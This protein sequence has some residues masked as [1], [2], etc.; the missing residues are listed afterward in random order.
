VDVGEKEQYSVYL[1]VHGT[2]SFKVSFPRGFAVTNYVK[3]A[4]RVVT[5]EDA[6][7]RW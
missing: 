4:V 2:T 1:P 5:A 3:D 7:A 6:K